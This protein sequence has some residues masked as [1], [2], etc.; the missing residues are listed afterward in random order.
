MMQ[1]TA[2]SQSTYIIFGVLFLLSMPF[3]AGAAVT[4]NEIAWMGS[5][6]S[7]NDEWIELYND[8]G[9]AVSVDGWT[10]T[11]GMNL[12]IGLSGTITAGSYAVLER[13]DDDAAP[14]SAFLIYT[15]ALGNTG[16][17]LLLQR[18][19]G[20]I[21]DQISGGENWENIGGD[22]VTKETAQYTSA[23][24][25]TTDPT[26][27][28]RN[29][30]VSTPEPENNPEELEDTSDNEEITPK[31]VKSSGS[32]SR[33]KKQLVLPDPKLVFTLQA[34]SVA[35]VHQPISFA[36]EPEGITD[37]LLNSVQ[38]R[39]NFGDL[40]TQQGRLITHQYEY[41]GTYVVVIDGTFKKYSAS[42]R[43]KITV[44]PVTFSMTKNSAGDV[45]VHNDSKYEVD[46][47]RYRVQGDSVIIFPENTIL[48]PSATLTIPKHTIGNSESAY[49][50]DQ[51]QMAVA[52]IEPGA[53]LAISDEV[54]AV[55]QVNSFAPVVAAPVS[56]STDVGAG[57]SFSNP[58]LRIETIPTVLEPETEVEEPAELGV[59]TAT[60]HDADVPISS[61]KLPF[62]G[63]IGVLSLGILAVYAGRVR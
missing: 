55:P 54:Q 19:D 9:S 42:L 43:H 41:P 12:D 52:S 58:E 24:W 49:L 2:Q 7:A 8:G 44:L 53:T 60:V 5:A 51:E 14:S 63:L 15:G 18:S 38:F 26:P 3:N 22:N 36:V 10:L 11:D 28:A 46:V 21:E 35:Y 13:T 39:W 32:S 27:G 45:Q 30:V 34:P 62:L 29:S 25:V 61:D 48:L 47:S 50:Y 37:V 40:T 20:S 23:G 57:F 6:N 33:T 1:D 31:K 56:A 59:Q 4:I 16:A 17:T